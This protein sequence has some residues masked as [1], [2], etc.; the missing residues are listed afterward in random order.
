MPRS[1]SRVFLLFLGL[2]SLAIRPAAAQTKPPAEASVGRIEH[3]GE[4]ASTNAKARQVD[5]WLPP[6]YPA[7]GVR[8]QVLYMHDGQNLF[9]SRTAAYGVA[10]DVDDCLGRLIAAETVEPTI[11]VGV[12]NTNLRFAEYAPAKPYWALPAAFRADLAKERPGEPL[13]DGYLKFLVEELKPMI[14][15]RYSTKPDRA[16]TWV[17]GSSMGGLISLYASL[18]YPAVFAGAACLSTH[19]PLSLQVN[20][21]AFPT[22]MLWYLDEKLPK[23]RKPRLYFDFGTATLDARYPGHQA[24]VDSLLV[25]HRYAP[26]LR[27]LTRRFEG[28]EHNEAAWSRRLDIPLTFLLGRTAK[29]R[30]TAALLAARP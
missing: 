3:L 10:W 28:A 27:R 1:F 4:I 9:D 16:H 7:P 20:V 18:E 24:R 30:R 17:A 5:V 25:K 21:P 14:D 6:G 15:K 19:W 13:S 2:S 8:Y 11:V 23:R 29:I 12:W 22:A 26:P